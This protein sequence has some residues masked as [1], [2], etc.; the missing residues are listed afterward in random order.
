MNGSTFE[1]LSIMQATESEAAYA[2]KKV[3]YATLLEAVRKKIAQTHSG[4]LAAALDDANAAEV[5]KTLILKYVAEEL[6]G[7]DFDREEMVERIFHDMAG[8][9]ILTAYLLDQ[10]VEEININRFDKI[11]IN[12]NKGTT[13]LT[14]KDAYDTPEMALDVVKRMVRIGGGLL[15]AQCPAIDSFIGSGTRITAMIPPLVPSEAGVSASIRKQVRSRITR[16]QLVS[17]GSATEDMLDFLVCCLCYGVSIGVA[18]GTGSGKSTL[19]NFLLNEYI[20]TNDDYNSRIY[21]IEDSRELN[22]LDYEEKNQRPSRVIY[23]VTQSGA[24]PVTMLDLIIKS[25]RFDPA[26]IVPAEVRDGAAFQAASAGQTGHT[27]LTSFHADGAEDAYKRLLTL[28][29]MAG[30]DLTDSRIMDMCV[31]AWPIVIFQK[32]LRDNSRKVMEVF[33]ATGHDNCHVQGNMLFRFVTEK[34]ERD[35]TGK[36][37]KV[38]GHHEQTGSISPALFRRLSDSGAPE[39]LLN[40]LF[41]NVGG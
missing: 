26:I 12:T 8:L 25:L 19:M 34:T 18:G 17:S 37:V 14:G 7:T 4:E 2:K 11:E 16:E 32:Q 27:I 21:V 23:T 22:L 36:I 10:N 38:H 24:K 1:F 31:D 39:E 6:A 30:N 35:A 28:C 3:E 20:R 15:D 5:L 33:E 9:G 13:I 40:R 29:N 41:P